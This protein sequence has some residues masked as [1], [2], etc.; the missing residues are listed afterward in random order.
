M[1][2]DN[3]QIQQYKMLHWMCV[4]LLVIGL[5]DSI[6]FGKEVSLTE[7]PAVV[8]DT[9]VREIGQALIE[10]IDRDKDDDEIVYEVDAEGDG[11]AIEL[12]VAGDGSL[13]KKKVEEDIAL[14]ELPPIVNKTVT[15]EVRNL[16]IEEVRRKTKLSGHVSYEIEARGEGK[17]IDLEVAA[18]GWVL[19]KKVDDADDD[20]NDDLLR[21]EAELLAKSTSPTLADIAPYH[22]ALVFYEYHIQRPIKGRFKGERIRVAHWGI[23]DKQP[24]AILEVEIGQRRALALR[25]LNQFCQLESIYTSD[26]LDLNPEIPLYHDIGQQILQNQ[27]VVERYDYNCALSDTMPAFWLLK[28]QLNLVVLGDSRGE[29]GVLAKL[30]FGQENRTT[31]MA[32]NL[33]VSG[34]PLQLQETVVNEYLL[35]LPELEWVV[36]QLSPRVVSV[37]HEDS[38]NKRL[39]RSR[40][41]SFDRDNSD[42]LWQPPKEQK[43]TVA[44]LTS[45]PYVADYWQENPWGSQSDDDV[46]DNP[47]TK[48]K[49]NQRWKI[50]EKRWNRLEAMMTALNEKGIRVLLYLS[51]IHP[52]IRESSVVDDD[53]TTREGYQELVGRLEKLEGQYS[54]LVFVDLLQ[55]GNHDFGVE[56]FRGL[57]HLNETGATKLTQGLEEIRLRQ[58]GS[59]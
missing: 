20:D 47:K 42:A 45:I 11:I 18:D 41:F 14:S 35:K 5:E 37:Y 34:A 59:Q 57:D 24:Q 23:Y 25:P 56:M 52:I 6:G 9:I 8:R 13:Q 50:S 19:Y 2:D 28:D 22:D 54:N 33:S 21:I 51:P 31:P 38:T 1:I 30:F 48:R 29:K 7:M 3:R 26:T 32:Y 55:G 12:K 4:I 36:Y 16:W 43:V 58:Q 10:D 46:W 49:W 53:G 40:G 17:E 27:S 39:L 15:R 44:E